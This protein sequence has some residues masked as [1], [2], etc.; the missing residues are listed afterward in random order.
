MEDSKPIPL[1]ARKEVLIRRVRQ[2]SEQ[3]F[4]RWE[5]NLADTVLGTSLSI[6]EYNQLLEAADTS[7]ANGQGISNEEVEKEIDGLL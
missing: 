4:S 5:S 1:H 7:I 3:D 6:Q 2:L